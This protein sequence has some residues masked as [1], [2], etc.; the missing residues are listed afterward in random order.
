M[1]QVEVYNGTQIK[2][3]G[4]LHDIFPSGLH[5]MATASLVARHTRLSNTV[6]CLSPRHAIVIGLSLRLPLCYMANAAGRLIR[7]RI[8]R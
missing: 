8:P 4:R 1:I 2:S 6:G 5:S 3:T 7:Q